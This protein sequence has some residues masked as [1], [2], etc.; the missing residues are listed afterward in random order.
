[1]SHPITIFRLGT[2]CPETCARL[3]GYED[4]IAQN[5]S[6]ASRCIDILG[7]ESPPAH[8]DCRAVI[9]TGSAHMVDERL[10]WSEALRPWLQEAVAR[11]LPLLGICYGHQL[12]A[13]ALGGT[14]GNNPRG[15][16]IGNITLRR[17]PAC[18]DD[19]LF[20]PL[21]ATFSANATHVQSVLRL[22]PGATALVA[23]D[24]D[25]HH[26]Y[27]IGKYAWGVQFHPEFGQEGMRD[28]IA[29][30][31]EHLADADALIA[32]VPAA[33]PHATALLQRF[34]QLALNR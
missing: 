31:R 23:N 11:E 9:L 30:K 26:A 4:W 10:P 1:M 24:H 29:Q 13:D 28:S 32:A 19:P 5:L 8:A 14:V 27:R 21:P 20:A 16:E 18:D 7:G 22:P 12:L 15:V 33:N 3:G 17:L 25:P 34:V 6:T 2:P